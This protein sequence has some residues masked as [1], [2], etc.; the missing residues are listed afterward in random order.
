MTCPSITPSTAAATAA[1][2][3]RTAGGEGGGTRPKD[4]TVEAGW[5]QAGFL[6]GRLG[7]GT[8]TTS[9][10][11]RSAMAEPKYKHRAS[12]ISDFI[13]NQNDSDSSSPPTSA[14][15]RFE[16]KASLVNAAWAKLRMKMIPAK[17]TGGQRTTAVTTAFIHSEAKNNFCGGIAY[18]TAPQRKSPQ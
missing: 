18:E 9:E 8:P 6:V 12:T 11:A 13:P 15:K 2:P 14:P 16:P 3:G 7:L 5:A 1:I 10:R 4:L 17:T